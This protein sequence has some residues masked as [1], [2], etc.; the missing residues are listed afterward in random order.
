MKGSD[1]LRHYRHKASIILDKKIK[2]C[3]YSGWFLINLITLPSVKV[4][5]LLL[6]FISYKGF[7]KDWEF[8]ST[9]FFLVLFVIIRRGNDPKRSVADPGYLVTGPLTCSEDLS[10][11]SNVCQQSEL[12]LS[13][14]RST[15]VTGSE[16]HSP[17]FHSAFSGLVRVIILCF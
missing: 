17:A 5:N 15:S 1:S 7:I 13:G 4:H 8:F 12:F 11:R 14:P 6:D 2:Y 9:N 3:H 16:T 10:E